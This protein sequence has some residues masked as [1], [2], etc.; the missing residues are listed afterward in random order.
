LFKGNETKPREKLMTRLLLPFTYGVEMDVLESLVRLASDQH[1]TLIP[2]SLVPSPAMKRKGVRLELL[3][4]SQDF[5]EA[6]RHKAARC[7]V[8]VEPV[9]VV[10]SDVVQGILTCV[11]KL[12]CDGILLASRDTCGS[13]LDAGVI[14]HLLR[15]N[16]CTLFVV[17][18][19]SKKRKGNM[20]GSERTIDTRES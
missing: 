15:I 10:T 1:A 16:P 11:D 17:Y 3:Q 7:R 5:L 19:P 2:L 8:P 12:H 4:Q 9:E 20:H 6:V 18:F 13:L 14:H